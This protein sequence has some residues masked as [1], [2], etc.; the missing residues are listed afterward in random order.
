[1][2]PLALDLAGVIC[3]FHKFLLQGNLILRRALRRLRRERISPTPRGRAAG[4]ALFRRRR[5]RTLK[6]LEKDGR[7]VKKR[8]KILYPA[9]L[10]VKRFSRAD[11]LSA[12]SDAALDLHV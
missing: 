2:H 4:F 9:A 6:Y 12:N 3:S 5:I 1:M 7:A 10:R 8:K 11:F